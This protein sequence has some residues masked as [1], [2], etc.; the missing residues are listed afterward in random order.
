[1]NKDVG[2][3]IATEYPVYSM[4]GTLNESERNTPQ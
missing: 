2:Q 4:L 3:K 1:M